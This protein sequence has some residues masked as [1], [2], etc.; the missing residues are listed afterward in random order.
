MVGSAYLFPPEGPSARNAQVMQLMSPEI[1]KL[2]EKYKDDAKK[3][4][5]AQ[6]DL[7][8]KYNHNPLGGC[9]PMF[10][11]LPIFLGLYRSIM[12]DISLRQAPLIPGAGP[13]PEALL[14]AEPFCF[15]KTSTFVKPNVVYNLSLS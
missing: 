11:Q 10:L 14:I 7:F 9:L 8:R 6:Q 15:F 4:M 1:K 5:A 13:G 2:Q 12:V 3:K